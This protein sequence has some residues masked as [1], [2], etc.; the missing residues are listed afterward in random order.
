M[1]QGV[2]IPKLGL[3]ME[4]ATLLQWHVP[5]DGRVD[6]GAVLLTIETDKITFDVEAEASGFLEQVADVGDRLKIG[7]LVGYLHERA[8]QRCGA[9]S[10]AVSGVSAPAPSS[11]AAPVFQSSHPAALTVACASGGRQLVSP[12][13]RRLAQEHGLALPQIIGSG[14]GGA[15][16]RRDVL[17]TAAAQASAPA[18]APAAPAL[19]SLVAAASVQRRPMSAMRRTISQRMMHSLHS[20][21]QMTGFGRIDMGQAVAWRRSLVER[22][23]DLGV[24]ITYTDLL[25]KACACVLRDMPEINAYID[26][27]DIVSLADIHIGLAVAVDGGLVVPVLRNIDRL[28]L[29]E[30]AQQ[31][32]QLI[33]RAR[34]GKLMPDEMNGG[35][36]TLSNFGS[37]GGDFETPILNWPQ[38]ALLG[39]GQISDEAVVRDGQ[40][41]ARP[42]MM[43]SLTFDHRLIDGALAG[44]FRSRLRELLERPALMMARMR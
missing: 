39:I 33:A 6:K 1:S 43:I 20:S 4:E 8:G 3:T 42:M 2:H 28:S 31:R 32:E 10:P 26:G 19:Q 21:A 36:F 34:T 35:S 40:V 27:D 12:V 38:S 30:L 44:R 41:V 24:R 18:Q 15:V 7:E 5:S 25:L 11:T 22:E 13:A 23:A 14:P 29:V 37:Y 17:A 16:L 9:G